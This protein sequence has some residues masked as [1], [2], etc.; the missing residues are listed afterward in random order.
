MQEPEVQPHRTEL[1]ALKARRL[2][3][4]LMMRERLP[5]VALPVERPALLLLARL[6]ERRR[7]LAWPQLEQQT[8]LLQPG[9][10]AVWLQL[11]ESGAAVLLPRARAGAGEQSC[12]ERAWRLLP[13]RGQEPAVEQAFSAQLAQLLK[14]PQR[15]SPAAVGAQD[16][17]RR[18]L[19]A[20]CAPGWPSGH[21]LAL[22][23]ATSQSWALPLLQ[24]VLLLARRCPCLC[25]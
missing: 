10:P 23:R 6:E 1:Q 21:R 15:A 2:L 19:P 14:R 17:S 8:A 7:S 11:P 3:E 9:L 4:P 18:A 20:L 16:G 12:A 13:E 5:A 24:R 25:G 22:R